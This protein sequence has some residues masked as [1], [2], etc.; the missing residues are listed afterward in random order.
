MVVVVGRMSDDGRG[1]VGC[2]E[3]AG[4]EEIAVCGMQERTDR[5][6]RSG[7]VC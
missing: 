1:N 5:N 2:E 7:V 6:G 3:C 4:A